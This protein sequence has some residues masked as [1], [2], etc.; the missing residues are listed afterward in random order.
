MTGVA[1]R[2]TLNAARHF[3]GA[4]FPASRHDLIERARNEGAGQDV[5]EVLES[6]P[7][8]EEFETLADLMKAY[9]ESDQ[10]PQ[11]G[12]IDIKP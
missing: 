1:G 9:G 5:L 4:H 2:S 7:H 11:T 10:A 12:V 6:F 3:K 8:G